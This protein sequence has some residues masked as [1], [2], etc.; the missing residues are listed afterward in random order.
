MLVFPSSLFQV[1]HQREGEEKR[2]SGFVTGTS[3]F[4]SSVGVEL[5]RGQ[6]HLSGVFPSFLPTHHPSERAPGRQLRFS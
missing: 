2:I 4:S 1:G 5:G 6:A 3:P